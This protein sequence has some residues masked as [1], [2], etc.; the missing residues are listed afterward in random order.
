MRIWGGIILTALCAFSLS[1]HEVNE[2]RAI[3]RL[4]RREVD[5]RAVYFAD[6]IE[7]EQ[8]ESLIFEEDATV[9]A[10]KLKLNNGSKVDSLGHDLKFM[11]VDEVDADG[12]QFDTSFEVYQDTS[13]QD[14]DIGENGIKALDALKGAPGVAGTDGLGGGDGGDGADI[15]ILSPVIR[16][17]ITLIT[18]GGNGGRGGHGG[19]GGRGGDGF[20]GMD[21]RTLYYFRGLENIPMDTLIGLGTS[22]G[23]PYVGQV[24]LILQIFNGI[25]IGDGFDGFDGG[26]GGEGGHGG[27]GG[28]GGH[29]GNIELIFGSQVQGSKI[30]V[31]TRGGKGGAAGL[32]GLG[33]VG[34]VGGAGGQRGDIWAREGAPGKSG[35]AGIAGMA[36]S[37]GVPGKSGTIKAVETGDP[38]WVSCYVRYR[39]AID[40]GVPKDLASEILKSCS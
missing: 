12:G 22:L 11:V 40:S 13:G 7:L 37:P 6:D 2:Q 5:G 20:S 32:G 14:G 35:A 23:V 9:Y 15:S 4:E 30:Y 26:K 31:S 28:N 27:R 3:E 34:G 16:G 38:E 10:R 19:N 25:R 17:N 24:L 21:A 8:K 39:L 18:R 1:A 33:G 36:G 29:G